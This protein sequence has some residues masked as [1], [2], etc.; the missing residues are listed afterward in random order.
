LI[1]V[2]RKSTMPSLSN[3]QREIC[4]KFGAACL[5]SDDLLKIGISKTFDP[6]QFPIN[7]PRHPQKVIPQGG[8]SGLGK[9]SRQVTILS[10]RCTPSI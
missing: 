4:L 7:G 5:V 1:L 3:M 6:A 10:S 9:S 8:M 2:G